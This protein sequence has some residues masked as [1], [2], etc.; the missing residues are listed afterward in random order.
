[1]EQS[2]LEQEIARLNDPATLS[3]VPPA[4][5]AW[6]LKPGTLRS[7]GERPL[8]IPAGAATV[9]LHLIWQEREFPN[10]QAR[11]RRFSDDKVVRLPNLS[12]PDAGRIIRL[13]LPTS[14]LS[15]GLYRVQIH[16]IAADGEASA[17]AEYDFNVVD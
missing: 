7:E 2:A 8:K 5:D 13:R 12:P 3:G 11:M 15:K 14:F 6:L 1:M 17:V 10:Y 4:T 9:E 16:G